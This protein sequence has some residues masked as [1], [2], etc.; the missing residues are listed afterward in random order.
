M[1]KLQRIF[2]VAMLLLTSGNIKAQDI[3]IRDFRPNITSLIGSVNPIYDNTGQACSVIK[4]LVRDTTFVVEANQGIMKRTSEIGEIIVYVPTTT[5]RLT[6]RH[7]GM[8]PLRYELPMR[9]EPKKTYDALLL[10]S[11]KTKDSIR[12]E[13]GMKKEKAPKDHA[14]FVMSLGYQIMA[15]SGPTIAIGIES[16]HHQIEIGGTLGLQKSSELHL[17]DS[18]NTMIATRQYSPLR[19]M[20]RYG[21]EFVPVKS[22][23]VGPM[24]GANLNVFNS[25]SENDS[26]RDYFKR[27]SSFSLTPGVRLSYMID[28]HL[29]VHLTP[30]YGLGIYKSSNCK[31]VSNHNKKFKQWTDGFNVSL[32]IS[33][34]L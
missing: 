22:F 13:G 10:V 25:K 7:A 5:K 30:E 28:K 17:Y 26:Y 34:T 8:L 31:V 21:Y 1:R 9:L 3:E 19:V 27:A 11:E 6:I 23:G 32:G 2:W 16:N 4:F 18:N 14:H 24:I 20:L 33:Y 12:P 15:I 29:K